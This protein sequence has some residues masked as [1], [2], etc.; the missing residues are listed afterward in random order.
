ME[1]T[2]RI[3][4]TEQ[5]KGVVAKI[6]YNATGD[7]NNDEVLAEAKRLFDEAMLYSQEKSMLKVGGLK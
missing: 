2:L 5:S 1:K 7:F 6:D 4:F 3:E